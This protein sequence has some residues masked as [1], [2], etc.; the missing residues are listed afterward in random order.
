MSN[1]FLEHTLTHSARTENFALAHASTGSELADQFGSAGSQRGRK[2]GEQFADQSKLHAEDPVAALRFVFYLRMVT[3][4]TRFVHPRNEETEKTD[5]VQRG[6]GN[7]DE[8]FG[9]YLWYA[10]TNPDVFYGNIWL[11]CTVGRYQDVYD[12][13]FLARSNNLKIDE[14]RL[15]SAAFEYAALAGEIDLFKKYAPLV[16]ASSKISTDRAKVMNSLARTLR[17]ILGANDA[18]MRRWKSG[19]EAHVWQQKIS[20]ELYRQINFDAIPG[21]ALARLTGGD[22]LTNNDLEDRYIEWIKSKPVA[23]FTGYPYELGKRVSTDMPLSR[24]L[25]VDRQFDGLIKTGKSDDGA[26]TG[27]VWCALD[28]SGSMSMSHNAVD[29]SGTLPLAVCLSLGIYFSVLNTGPFHR[30]AIMFDDISRVIELKGD[31]CDMWQQ[32]TSKSTAWGS[33]NYQSV[34]DEIVRIRQRYPDVPLEDFPDTLLVVSDMQFN[35]A[36]GHESR[37]HNFNEQTNHEKAMNKLRAV[38]PPHWVRDFRVIWWDVTGRRTDNKPTHIS[39]GGTYVFSGFDG[40]IISLLLGGDAEIETQDE[41]EDTPE[42]VQIIHK[43]LNQQILQHALFPE[44]WK[45]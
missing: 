28:T 11:M 35:P 34:I 30:H 26:I 15:I 23:K 37:G 2:L 43:A 17:G 22:F 29:D 19:G 33:T 8:S 3:R 12:L 24:R 21:R 20:R 32:I 5:T 9:R 36:N 10:A 16:K 45:Q 40:A 41:D 1:S 44:K 42:L 25:T 13:C 14:K 4:K 31:F 39:E 6:Q 27:N 18:Q 7:R 38:F